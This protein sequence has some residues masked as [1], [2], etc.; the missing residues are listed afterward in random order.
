MK[1]HFAILFAGAALA[2][3]SCSK[4][5]NVDSYEDIHLNIT[6]CNPGG[7]PST[8]AL[9][10]GWVSGD[11][12]NIWFN[13]RADYKPNLTLTYNGST[14]DASK[15]STDILDGIATHSNFKVIW[16]GNND[17]AHTFTPSTSGTNT[18]FNAK[19]DVPVSR[20]LFN[21]QVG[22]T[23]DPDTKT[24]TANISELYDITSVQ[25][26]V[27]GLPAGDWS[28][29][30]PIMEAINYVEIET[31]SHISIST[32]YADKYI[33]GQPAADGHVF[34]AGTIAFSYKSGSHEIRFTLTDGTDTYA[35]E[36]GSKTLTFN[37]G[38]AYAYPFVAIKLPAF[39]GEDSAPVYWIKQ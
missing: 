1:K 2:V 5:D 20:V 17:L 19:D 11:V 36:A 21:S 18:R 3:L 26:T 16:E 37:R 33:L 25:V 24:L 8:K 39:D 30:S 22:Y 34:V 14:W 13:G 15:V 6:V 23:Y 4:I 32:W 38:D 7:D 31:G 35:Y 27:P 29:K 28:I 10:S 12:L 9:K